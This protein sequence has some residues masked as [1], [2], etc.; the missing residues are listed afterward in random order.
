MSTL[1]NRLKNCRKE[2]GYT[3]SE[4]CSRIGIKQ[5]TLS[6]LENDK[7]PTSAYVPHLAK[8]Y[9]VEAMWLATG[10]GSKSSQPAKA[11]GET[12]TKIV[13]LVEKLTREQQAALLHFLQLSE[14]NSIH[15]DLSIT[16]Q[17]PEENQ[18]DGLD[19]RRAV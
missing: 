17:P 6:E 3:Q 19:L 15:K 16:V 11:Q 7:Y 2:S 12:I 4:V 9:G 8:L 14:I 18:A 1:G 5:G 13:S 10:R